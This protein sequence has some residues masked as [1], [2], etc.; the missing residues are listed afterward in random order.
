MNK[1][2]IIESLNDIIPETMFNVDE[3]ERKRMKKDV[4]RISERIIEETNY[5]RID[6]Q[7]VKLYD[8]EKEL[9]LSIKMNNFI[10][11]RI[12]KE[13]ICLRIDRQRVKLY[14]KCALLAEIKLDIFLNEY[15][16]KLKN[17]E[18]LKMENCAMKEI[19]KKLLYNNFTMIN[20]NFN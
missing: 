17:I 3:Q 13:T 20:F 14:N 11:E 12:I 18:I 1:R 2:K 16:N 6:R 8:K 4:E 9:L 5:V 7:D 15:A 19:P 10:T